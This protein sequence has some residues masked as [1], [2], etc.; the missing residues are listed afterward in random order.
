M[1]RR[2]FFTVLHLKFLFLFVSLILLTNSIFS[3]TSV[4]INEFH[5][6]NSSTDQG[7]AIE[8]AGPAGT[9]L[10]GW[11]LVLYNGSNGTQYNTTSLTGTIPNQ[12]NGFGTLVTNYPTNGIQNGG[13][14]G[15]VLL[16]DQNTVIQFLSYEGSFTAT[17]GPANGMTSTDIG[18][19]ESF[20]TPI[21]FSLQ[22]SGTGTT[23]EDFI[24]NSPAQNSFG[25]CNTNQNFGG[26]GAPFV[27]STNP[28]NN[29]FDIPVDANIEINFNESLEITPL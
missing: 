10:T 9:D 14:D 7:E 24:W 2:L 16:D 20:S 1:F 18:V 4:F 23:Y 22:L 28:A 27:S 13:P 12:C 21:G 15:I 17:N 29:A 11:S 25:D 26:D 19:S 5:Y 8:I 3:Q 6:D